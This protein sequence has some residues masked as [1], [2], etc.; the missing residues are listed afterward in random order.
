MPALLNSPL[1]RQWKLLKALS[2]SHLGVAVKDLAHEAGVSLKTVRRDLELLQE[3]G[4]PLEEHAV[5][6]GRKQWRIEPKRGVPDLSFTFDEA[7]AL[8]LA[9][10]FLEP[11]AGTMFW[12]AAQQAFKKIRVSLGPKVIKYLDRM[13]GSLHA[14]HPG[15][16]DYSRHPEII[17]ELL[18]GIEDGKAVFITYQSQQA[19]EP[20]TYDIYPYGLTIHRGSMYLVGYAPQH[21][22]IRHWKVDRI[23]AAEATKVPFQ[24]PADFNLEQHLAGS[25][26][27][28]HGRNNVQVKIR[29]AKDVARFV[30]ES[31]WHASQQLTQ[32]PDGSLLAEFRLSGTIEIKSWAL[33]FGSRAEVMEPA[34]LRAEVAAELKKLV[35]LYDQPR[36]AKKR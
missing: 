34:E 11:L 21:Q 3:A 24:P 23:E 10:R 4:F 18:I 16:G 31:K 14:T 20:V 28:F 7:L 2:A 12:E 1:L 32:Q 15:S 36:M 8:Y 35:E 22:E 30:R 9:R 33:S 26:G 13:A 25:F 6:F 5:E 19:T 29:F 27:V 17:D